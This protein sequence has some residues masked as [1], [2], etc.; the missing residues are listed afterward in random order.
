MSHRLRLDSPPSAHA[1]WE[2][3][4]FST[5]PSELFGWPRILNGKCFFLF[6]IFYCTTAFKD[7]VNKGY[8]GTQSHL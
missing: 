5:F 7:T 2:E 1:P 6:E 3:E 4:D 8:E